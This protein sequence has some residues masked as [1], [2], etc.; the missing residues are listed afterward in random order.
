MPRIVNSIVIL[1]EPKR[2]FDIT[3]D[4]AN[5][6]T[7]F[8]E[9]G[10]ATVRAKE[11]A[12]RFTRLVFELGN[13]EGSKWTSWRLLDH[14]QLV[15]IAERSEPLFP[16]QYMHLKWIYEQ[17]PEGTRMTWYQDFELDEKFGTPLPEVL[18]RMNKHTVE[19]Q[20]LIKKTIESG[21]AAA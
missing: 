4:I 2:V 6:P 10:S 17:V 16:F 7:L 8:N 5:W 11:E 20:Q 15:A 9:Y 3:N 19:N 1:A 18:V 21:L 13:L 14:E 12:G